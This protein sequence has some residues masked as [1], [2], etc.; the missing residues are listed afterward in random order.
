MFYAFCYGSIGL[1]RTVMRLSPI[2]QQWFETHHDSIS[3][4]RFVGE[5]ISKGRNISFRTLMPASPAEKAETPPRQRK[6]LIKCSIFI[7]AFEFIRSE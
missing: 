6:H 4:I 1:K 3:Y 5:D 7:F 2:T